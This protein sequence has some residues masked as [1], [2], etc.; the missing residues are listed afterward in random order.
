MCKVI[1]N[2][3][4]VNLSACLRCSVYV[5]VYKQ[6]NTKPASDIRRKRQEE[7]YK[8]FGQTTEI[9][10]QEAKAEDNFQKGLKIRT[11]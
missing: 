9:Q 3:K 5:I 6:Q 11:S 10:R 2:T 8:V 1:T 4:H 7:K